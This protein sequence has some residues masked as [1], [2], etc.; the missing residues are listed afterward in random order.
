M[1]TS[2]T[3]LVASV[4]IL[5]GVA[6][7]FSF[8]KSG[9]SPHRRVTMRAM[10]EEGAEQTVQDLDLEDMQELFEAADQSMP[11]EPSSTP[12]VAFDPKK[13][14]GVTGPLGFFDPADLSIDID[15][16]TFK[17][18]REAEI[19]H[20]RVCMLAFLGLVTGE[21]AHPLF[22][23]EITG[24]AIYQFQQADAIVPLFWMFVLWGIAM[25][26]GQTII[27]RWQSPS[28][29]FSS[30]SGRAF[31][32]EDHV[33]GDYGFD[34]L[35]LAPKDT[36]ALDTMKT[37]ELNNGRLAMIGVAGIVGQELATNAVIF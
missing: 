8:Q 27:D 7:A 1:K 35:S 3:T 18:Y 12:A 26:E 14:I 13:E 34:P 19:K 33:A 29:T 9:M 6:T 28:I 24:P 37:K 16:S 2:T 11:S 32:A 15:E 10:S 30:S 23:G 25:Y 21:I 31:L 20:G 22:N 4:A 36:K 5:S 17:L